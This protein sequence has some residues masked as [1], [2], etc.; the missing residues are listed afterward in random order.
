MRLVCPDCGGTGETG[1]VLLRPSRCRRC[2]GRGWLE[3][4]TVINIRAAP[5]DWR[6]RPDHIYI[7]RAHRSPTFGTI[8]RSV[9]ANPFHGDRAEAI[10]HY[11]ELLRASPEMLR[12]LPSLGGMTLVCWCRPRP[13]HGDALVEAYREHVIRPSASDRRDQEP[14][15]DGTPHESVRNSE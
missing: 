3:E 1:G 2:W 6:D 13:C 8:P 14:L 7:G 15:C 5:D 4:P 10:E 11:R 9:W 12:A